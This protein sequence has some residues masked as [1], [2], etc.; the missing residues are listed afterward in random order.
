MVILSLSERRQ[1][2]EATVTEEL[3]ERM[4]KKQWEE[5]LEANQTK[6]QNSLVHGGCQWRRENRKGVANGG[7]RIGEEL[8]RIQKL[9]RASK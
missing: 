5:A 2:W 7:E 8:H 3:H 9:Q 6:L 1:R 4:W